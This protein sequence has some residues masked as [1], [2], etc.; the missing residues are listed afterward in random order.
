MYVYKRVFHVESIK[1]MTIIE[2]EIEQNGRTSKCE[3][4]Y[5]LSGLE[6]N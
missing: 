3:T 1:L 5:A 6:S 4:L 2:A